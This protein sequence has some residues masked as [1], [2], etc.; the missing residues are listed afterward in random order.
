MRPKVK[1]PTT[2][3]EKVVIDA[4]VTRA[5]LAVDLGVPGEEIVDATADTVVRMI[6]VSLRVGSA[7]SS[8]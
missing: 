7:C 4:T 3:L 8:A 6:K 5:V 2:C 1:N